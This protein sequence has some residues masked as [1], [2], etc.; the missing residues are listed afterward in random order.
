MT[1]LFEGVQ[2]VD[3]AKLMLAVSLDGNNPMI[4]NM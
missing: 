2:R 3:H 4:N 1:K